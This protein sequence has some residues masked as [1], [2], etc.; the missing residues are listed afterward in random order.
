MS[1]SLQVSKDDGWSAA[2]ELPAPSDC[3]SLPLSSWQPYTDTNTPIK[4]WK[5]AET[6]EGTLIVEPLSTAASSKTRVRDFIHPV[7]FDIFPKR[8]PLP[9]P[10][11]EE[12]VSSVRD[13]Y[14]AWVKADP[15]SILKRHLLN[16]NSANPVIREAPD[17]KHSCAQSLDQTEET[18]FIIGTQGPSVEKKKL[19]KAHCG[20][21]A[22]HHPAK[23]N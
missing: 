22:H 5:P 23:N 12:D 21:M 10:V 9:Y 11:L 14:T 16:V 8:L 2:R 20:E 7:Q 1:Q 19:R 13:G 15:A 4:L 18:V 3:P 6:Q 17:K